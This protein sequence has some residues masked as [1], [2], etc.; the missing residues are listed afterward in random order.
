MSHDWIGQTLSGRYRV[1]SQLGEGGMGIAFGAVDIRLDKPVVIKTPHAD[2]VR[3]PEARSRFISEVEALAKLSHP[4]I[5][6]V[7]DVGT[8]SRLPFMVL[9][10]LAGGSLSGRGKPMT[11]K[12]VSEW[13]ADAA[14]ALDYL[15]SS[16]VIHR[17][18]K[19]GN[20]LF[21]ESGRAYVA[22]FGIVKVISE[23]SGGLTRTGF[24]PGTL[25]YMAP[26]TL[27]H[28]AKVS[29][30]SD[31][32]A[33]AVT[34]YEMLTGHPPLITDS[35]ERFAI[36]LATQKPEP[37]HAVSSAVSKQTS[38]V[39]A[40]A[41]SKGAA[42]R[43]KTCGD[44]AKAFAS[45]VSG[46]EPAVAPRVGSTPV[47]EKARVPSDVDVSVAKNRLPRNVPW[48]WQWL[49]LFVGSLALPML[50]LATGAEIPLS[51]NPRVP[52]S[53]T[54]TRLDSMPQGL[55]A[56]AQAVFRRAEQ[57]DAIAQYDL[58]VMY[59]KGK[60][61]P[62]D[63][64]EA[65]E[66]LRKAAEQGYAKAENKLGY[67]YQY[68]HG[69]HEDDTEAVKWYFKAAEQGNAYAQYNLGVMYQYRDG[70][71]KDD[72][73]AVKWFRKA[74]EQ[75]HADG[76]WSLGYMYYYGKGVPK[77]RA[78]AYVWFSVAATNGHWNAKERL[79]K[80]KLTPE[81]LATAER[82]A[83][84]LNEQINANKAD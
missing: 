59:R 10:L 66:W 14:S 30:Q 74:A 4:N 24:S 25:W 42:D 39:V 12:R 81:Q 58:G 49:L 67:M 37:L 69:V 65:L 61:A 41:L 78:E 68:G 29:P 60:G 23:S 79:A 6:Q 45:A 21:G 7:T 80:A 46:G 55:S 62:K 43:F 77:D 40:K 84:E 76:Q 5:V 20:I 11:V 82:R 19:P 15:H 34:V 32:Y 28:G 18:I 8:H 48:A 51:R 70:T 31:Q 3:D 26:E 56:S 54:S 9:E 35:V 75:G 36:L 27:L 52:L 50:I 16:G 47:E 57:G 44:F 71:P 38:E 2:T 64:A 22:D 73:E 63:D 72:T 53:I 33:L 1:T 17:D 83:A 13:L